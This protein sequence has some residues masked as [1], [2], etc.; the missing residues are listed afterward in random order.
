MNVKVSSWGLGLVG[1][2]G[3]LGLDGFLL[4]GL[5]AGLSDVFVEGIV[6]LRM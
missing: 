4:A 5:L 1:L 6:P 3:L 2:L